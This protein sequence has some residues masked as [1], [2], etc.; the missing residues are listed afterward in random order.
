MY[1]TIGV[2]L[3]RGGTTYAAHLGLVCL[4]IEDDPQTFAICIE[5]LDRCFRHTKISTHSTPFSLKWC[6]YGNKQTFISLTSDFCFEKVANRI[7]FYIKFMPRAVAFWAK[8][9]LCWDRSG[10]VFAPWHQFALL[11]DCYLLLAGI[12]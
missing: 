2:K 12:V 1:A 11:H 9:I 7:N 10:M 4:S 6:S 5:L 3:L 8:K